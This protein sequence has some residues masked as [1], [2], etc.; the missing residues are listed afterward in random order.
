MDLFLCME[1]MDKFLHFFSVMDTA[2]WVSY[3]FTYNGMCNI[4]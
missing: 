3:F 4:K 2:Y 1:F